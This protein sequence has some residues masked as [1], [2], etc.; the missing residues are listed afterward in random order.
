MRHFAF[1]L[2]QWRVSS[3][4]LSDTVIDSPGL[5]CCLILEE[6]ELIL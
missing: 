4:C 2:H 6:F 5:F 3:L 1:V